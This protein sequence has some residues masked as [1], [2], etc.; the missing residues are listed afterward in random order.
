[1]QENRRRRNKRQTK[2]KHHLWFWGILIAI[3]IIC[4]SVWM[5][6]N[7]LNPQKHF[8]NLKTLNTTKTKYH[9]AK[10][11]FNILVIGSDERPNQVTGHTDSMLLVHANLNSHKY[12][13]VSI[14]RDSRIYMQ[15]FGYTKLTSVQS[16]YQEKYGAKKGVLMAV[17]TISSYLNVPVNYYLETNYWGFRSM[18]AAVGGIT[19]NLPFNVTLTHPWYADDQNKT[20]TKG[21]HNLDAKMVTEIVHERDSLPGTDFGRQ[22]LQE[23]ALVGIANKVSNPVNAFKIPALVNST[24]KFLVATNMNKTDM[25][26]I[27]LAVANNFDAKK[28]LHYFQLK[29]TNEVAY[30]NILENYNDE[31]ILNKADL[32]KIIS[33]KL[34][35]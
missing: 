23:D 6:W 29:G 3:L 2:K 9:Q 18:V 22:R 11:T 21:K 25:I 33:N 28:Q 4:G 10:G 13:I 32:Q 35:N 30:D 1:M 8:S 15:N 5:M 26:S 24:S 31:I 14:P 16:V 34:D 20:F 19:M 27:A 17:K 12:N 7:Y